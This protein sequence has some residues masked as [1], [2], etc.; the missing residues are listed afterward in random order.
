MHAVIKLKFRN[1]TLL[2]L[3]ILLK[4]VLLKI[5]LLQRALFENALNIL[6]LAVTLSL[7]LVLVLKWIF[8]DK[9]RIVWRDLKVVLFLTIYEIILGLKRL[10]ILAIKWIYLYLI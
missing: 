1:L 9:L 3:S 10:R 7:C 4:I 6:K 5:V 2:L 8:L